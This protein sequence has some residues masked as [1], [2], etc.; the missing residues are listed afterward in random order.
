MYERDVRVHELRGLGMFLGTSGYS[1]RTLNDFLLDIK[2]ISQGKN[3]SLVMIEDETTLT[4]N[5]KLE[6]LFV[7]VNGEVENTYKA[8]LF[9]DLD[10]ILLNVIINPEY[11]PYLKQISTRKKNAILWYNK[12]DE[13]LHFIGFKQDEDKTPF[14]H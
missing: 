11:L 13:K 3:G 14:Y 9:E 1:F 2:N 8:S 5:Y 10:N 12:R 7:D 6:S 4:P